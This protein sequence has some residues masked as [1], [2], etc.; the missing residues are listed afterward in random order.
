MYPGNHAKPRA[1]QA[2]FIMAQSGETVTYAELEKR[3]NQL[4]H[5]LRNCGLK[6]LD[7]YSIF[8]E[9][10]ARYIECCGAGERSGLYYTCI[11][12][13][14]TPDE[15]AYIVNN[16]ES[17]VLIFS[18]A[19][20]AVAIEALRQCPKIEVS[21]VVDGR[22]DGDR[23]VNLDDAT[24][25]MPATPITDES[26]GTAMLYSS[27]TT[28]QP[29][30]II[31]PLPEQPPSQQLPLFDFLQKLWR[32]REGL[33]YLSPAPLYH[34]APQ[35]A[36]NLVIRNGGTAI[37]MENYDPER[38][39]QLVEKHKPTHSQ[40]VP[41]MFSRMLKLP[42]AIRARYDLSSL[43]VVIHAAAP[44]P[45]QVKEQ[46]IAW[47]G[48]IIHEYYGATEGLGF[49]ACDSTQ[50]L[51]HRGTVGK[52]MLGDLH[53][54]DENMEPCPK[55]TSGTLWFKTATPF[56]YFNDSTK[57][58][59]ARSPDGSMSTVGDVGYV[60]DDGFLYLTD[61]ATFMIV[62]GGVNIYPQECE[63]LLITHSKVADAAVF[64]V[65][66]EDLGEEVKAVVQVMPG[67]AAD[68]NLV[69]ELI[70]FCAK[71]LSRQK[72]PRSIDFEAE[73]PRLPTGKLYKRVLR[74]RYWGDRK[75]RIV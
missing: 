34:S 12:S 1:G 8:M 72:C 67:V 73:L 27:G 4:V 44:C 60:D 54:L 68:S 49:A 38:Y 47:W 19:M 22:G 10:N 58:A 42:E 51:A 63:N 28:G 64:G 23:I 46:M 39:L 74:D 26:V 70:T 11:N 9:N 71:Y 16:S 55:G 62:S 32:Y 40:L 50:W 17:R 33:V 36:V 56:E 66:N 30:G 45:A 31:R 65:P 61:R 5:F 52:V 21:L 3:T 2:A 6:R 69:D 75:S 14:L 15:L 43:E 20:R 24:S 53:V 48:P 7:H 25:G 13:F 37:I 18:E 29:K 59:E 35:A 57:T 41:T